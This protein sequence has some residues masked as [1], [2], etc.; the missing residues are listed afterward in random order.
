MAVTISG[1]GPVAGVTTINTLPMPTD[2][3]E[4]IKAWVK[5][6]GTN[7]VISASMNV[8]GVVRSSTGNY[9]VTFTNALADANY[10]VVATPQES[11]VIEFP[12]IASQSTTSCT[13]QFVDYNASAYKD[14]SY[15]HAVFIR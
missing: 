9:V 1:S 6:N 14:A 5:F 12:R 11:G 7:G 13:I 10:V 4:N 15:V 2:S 8:S 3:L